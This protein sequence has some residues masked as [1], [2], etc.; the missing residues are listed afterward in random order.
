MLQGDTQPDDF[1]LAPRRRVPTALV[2]GFF[3]SG[4]MIFNARATATLGRTSAGRLEQKG[5]LPISV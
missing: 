3:K 4:S 2:C 1:A 5:E